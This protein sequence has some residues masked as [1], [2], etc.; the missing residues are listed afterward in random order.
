MVVRVGEARVEEGHLVDVLA[1]CGKISETSL[2]RLAVRREPERRLHQR[3]DLVLEE[4]GRVLERGS[5]SR[6][7]LPCQRSSAGLYSQVSTWLGP[8][9]MKS[10]ITRLALAG[11]GRRAASG[12][13]EASA[14]SR[15]PS[16]PSL[17]SRPAR[18]ISPKPPPAR[19]SSYR[20]RL[21][22]ACESMA[23][24]P[25]MRSLRTIVQGI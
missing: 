22:M 7:D 20:R 14:A 8:P 6:I 16:S 11:S 23:T 12:L 24:G 19:C 13:S 9:L 5:N 2:P 3:A 21:R 1:Q 4:A 18:P 17:L 10:Q 25:I 15:A